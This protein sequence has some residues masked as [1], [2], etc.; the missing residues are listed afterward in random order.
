MQKWKPSVL[1]AIPNL[2]SIHMKL[3]SRLIRWMAEDPDYLS[4]LAILAPSGLVPHDNARNFCVQEF[5]KTDHTHLFFIDSD[6][7]PPHNA[8]ETLLEA[9]KYVIAGMYPSMRYDPME[10]RTMLIYNV[11]RHVEKDGVLSFQ[12]VLGEGIEEIDSSGAGCLLIKREVLIAMRKDWFRF[13]YN[14]EGIVKY[15]EDISFC[16]KARK[17]GFPVYGD[18]NVICNHSKECFL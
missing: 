15:G 17:L 7:V 11:F 9:D 8:L 13:Q 2:G 18:F 16:R 14:D 3:A 12:N 6:V 1:I 5:L 4:G 10:R